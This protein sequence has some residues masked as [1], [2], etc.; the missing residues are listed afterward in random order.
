MIRRLQNFVVSW[1]SRKR[2]QNLWHCCHDG[3]SYSPCIVSLSVVESWMPLLHRHSRSFGLTRVLHVIRII[4]WSAYAFGSIHIVLS[5]A[6]C[7]STRG[8]ETVKLQS[9]FRQRRHSARSRNTVSLSDSLCPQLSRWHLKIQTAS[10]QKAL[11]R[12]K[13]NR[14]EAKGVW[15]HVVKQKLKPMSNVLLDH[16][17]GKKKIT[18]AVTVSSSLC[19]AK[20]V[21]SRSAAAGSSYS[22]HEPLLANESFGIKALAQFQECIKYRLHRASP[23]F[24]LKCGTM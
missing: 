7:D 24:R 16:I 12:A 10:V 19:C 5:L 20:Q 22:T 2:I 15:D 6:A 11:H 4:T 1:C 3:Q 9:A 18:S 17:L 8:T 14:L 23:K 13:K 21:W